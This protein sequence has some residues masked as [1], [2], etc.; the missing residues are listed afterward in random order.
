MY[1]PSS[2]LHNCLSLTLC[3]AQEPRQSAAINAVVCT[4]LNAPLLLYEQVVVP[5]D[6]V[7]PG[8][9]EKTAGAKKGITLL[10]TKSIPSCY[11]W[12]FELEP[13]SLLLTWFVNT[14]FL[15]QCCRFSARATESLHT[16]ADLWMTVSCAA[17]YINIV[18][19]PV[20]L[21]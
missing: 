4:A 12:N 7:H 19:L 5:V 16:K 11:F 2:L 8:A 6:R 1:A 15:L 9:V 20:N 13:F 10:I 17:I 3:Y 21:M 14:Y 18:D